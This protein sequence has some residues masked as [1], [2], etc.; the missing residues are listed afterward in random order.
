MT[1]IG[2][3]KGMGMNKSEM[4]KECAANAGVPVLM[5]EIGN[6]INGLVGLMETA[7]N[8][9][10]SN[11]KTIVATESFSCEHDFDAFTKASKRATELGY[12]CGSMCGDEPIALS[13]TAPYIAKWRNIGMEDYHKI[14][15]LI[16]SDDFRNKEAMLVLFAG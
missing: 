2:K 10:N 9:A 16:L 5:F 12:N 4:L 8:F 15:G 7:Q 6:G 11:N 13:K 14:Q 1:G 3:Q